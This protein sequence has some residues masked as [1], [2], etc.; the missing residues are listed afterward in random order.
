MSFVRIFLLSTF[1]VSVS[2]A[3]INEVR[4]VEWTSENGKK[5]DVKTHFYNAPKLD[6]KRQL[7]VKAK[8]LNK[9]KNPHELFF[10]GLSIKGLTDPSLRKRER[11]EAVTITHKK[12]SKLTPDQKKHVDFMVAEAEKKAEAKSTSNKHAAHLLNHDE[13]SV[14]PPG[15]V[16][17]QSSYYAELTTGCGGTGGAVG[18]RVSGLEMDTC[19]RCH[20]DEGKTFGCKIEMNYDSYSMN[21]TSYESLTCNDWVYWLEKN[22]TTTPIGIC[23]DNY[24]TLNLEIDS[25]AYPTSGIIKAFYNTSEGCGTPM[26]YEGKLY[27]PGVCY[28]DEN[29]GTYEKMDGCVLRKYENDATCTTNEVG[30]HDF[31]LYSDTCFDANGFFNEG[32]NMP[33]FDRS[34]EGYNEF[35]NL[36]YGRVA[37]FCGNKIQK[38]PS[39]CIEDKTDE[40]RPELCTRNIAMYNPGRS[41]PSTDARI[42]QPKKNDDELKVDS[43]TFALDDSTYPPTGMVDLTITMPPDVKHSDRYRAVL[44]EVFDASEMGK[45]RKDHLVSFKFNGNPVNRTMSFKME[46]PYDNYMEGRHEMRIKLKGRVDPASNEKN[47]TFIRKSCVAF[48]FPPGNGNDTANAA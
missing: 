46:M 35:G 39:Q 47:K 34:L 38:P 25:Y 10:G 5:L 4:T 8:V 9:K 1:L 43:A 42:C 3:S 12:V 23:V 6:K 40:I 32:G 20:D 36:T 22:T 13:V 28:A 30:F 31:D 7:D 37:Y 15:E 26:G 14:C 16:C 11:S 48:P 24:F 17:R 45:R 29:G 41:V 21:F 33:G 44:F 18:P 19:F 27:Q 2:S